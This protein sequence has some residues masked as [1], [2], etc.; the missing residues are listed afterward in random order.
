[1][2]MY[3]VLPSPSGRE[4]PN[5]TLEG[6]AEGTPASEVVPGVGER[7]VLIAGRR[8]QQRAAG[9]LPPLA[10]FMREPR[11]GAGQRPHVAPELGQGDVV[12]GG[13]PGP[14]LDVATRLG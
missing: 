5:R 3:L 13:H 14:Q 12:V 11:D 10:Q 7:V 9:V 2:R 1:M 6:I 8:R 4:N